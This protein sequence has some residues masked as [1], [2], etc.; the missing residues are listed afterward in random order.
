MTKPPPQGGSSTTSPA[1]DDASL[2]AVE[3]HLRAFHADYSPAPDWQARVLASVRAQDAATPRRARWWWLTAPALAAAALLAL[4]WPRA[5]APRPRQLAMTVL[6][7][8]EPTRGA[9]VHLGD[10]LRLR[11]TG[12]GAER[13]LWVYRGRD[14]LVV[15]CPGSSSC[16]ADD[17]SLAATFKATTVGEYTA[18]ALWSATPI[19]APTGALDDALAAA[20]RAGAQVQRQSFPVD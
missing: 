16:A 5:P 7:R 19:P 6:Q 20:A 9:A 12:D 4:L 14:E 17:T 13:A 1:D 18:I 11:L 10:E 8:A 3:A 15:S 2:G